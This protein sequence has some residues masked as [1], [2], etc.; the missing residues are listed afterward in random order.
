MSAKL[1]SL[2]IHHLIAQL[3]HLH[4]T[5]ST[6]KSKS[7]WKTDF[8]NIKTKI[9][10]IILTFNIH[11]KPCHLR[12]NMQQG[13]KVHGCDQNLYVSLSATLILLFQTSTTG[14]DCEDT[15]WQYNQLP[16]LFL[17][18]TNLSP[19]SSSLFHSFIYLRSLNP[20]TG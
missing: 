14:L 13:L 16:P 12:Q 2:L 3:L 9:Q 10:Y 8:R 19:Q 11:Y 4:M 20:R 1:T 7:T 18:C 17:C 15:M 5:I 6:S